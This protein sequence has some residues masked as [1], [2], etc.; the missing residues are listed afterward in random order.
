[1]EEKQATYIKGVWRNC[2]KSTTRTLRMLCKKEPL[3]DY[4]DFFL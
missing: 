4:K 2:R 3:F 1:M